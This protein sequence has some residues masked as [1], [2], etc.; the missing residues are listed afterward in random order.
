MFQVFAINLS[1]VKFINFHLLIGYLNSWLIIPLDTIS[2]LEPIDLD[3]YHSVNDIAAPSLLTQSTIIEWR[4]ISLFNT[5]F[6][7]ERK[8][9]GVL[10]F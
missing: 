2:R 7:S 8:C 10:L 9:D 5:F 6:V 4:S 3:G 1:P